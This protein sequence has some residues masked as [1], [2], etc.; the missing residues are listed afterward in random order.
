MA[1]T[2]QTPVDFD[3]LDVG[4]ELYVIDSMLTAANNFSLF[5]RAEYKLAHEGMLMI[6]AA[7]VMQLKSSVDKFNNSNTQ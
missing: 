6:I 7:R 2:T 3:M 5:E 4:D 1:K